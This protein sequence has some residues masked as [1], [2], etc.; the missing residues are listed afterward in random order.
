MYWSQ[1]SICKL[2]LGLSK[3]DGYPPWKQGISN[4]EW[5][6]LGESDNESP[7]LNESSQ[8]HAASAPKAVVEDWI[9]HSI[10]IPDSMMDPSQI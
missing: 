10:L 5:I 6:N 8:S 3:C 4:H 7:S 1:S 9:Q 2:A